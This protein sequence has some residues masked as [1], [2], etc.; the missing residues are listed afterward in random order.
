MLPLGSAFGSS[1]PSSAAVVSVLAGSSA[2]VVS[3]LAGSSALVSVVSS[4]ALVS[5]VSSGAS[6]APAAAPAPARAAAISTANTPATHGARKPERRGGRNEDTMAPSLSGVVE[7]R[8]CRG[9][10]RRRLGDRQPAL[11]LL[12]VVFAVEPVATR[13]GCREAD[14]GARVGGQVLGD[15]EVAEGEVVLGRVG[16][17]HVQHDLGPGRGL[18]GGRGP[19]GVDALQLLLGAAVQFDR[20][21][22][23]GL[24]GALV[25]G[26]VSSAVLC[27]RDGAAGGGQG[28]R[29]QGRNGQEQTASRHRGPS[30][31]REF[32]L[33]SGNSWLCH[34]IPNISQE[35]CTETGTRVRARPNSDSSS[36]RSRSRARNSRESTVPFGVPITSAASS[37]ERPWSST[38]V[39]ATR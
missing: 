30:L 33:P 13:F 32:P 8:G 25:G 21:R 11:H 27:G 26:T 9:G 37:Q 29:D 6:W 31:V 39:T 38:N 20:R 35:F 1:A 4:T 22:L 10:C 17:G 7:M 18:V 28:H 36:R 24:A 3:V 14:Q 12:L 15:L 16:V 23:G 5:V 34:R 2:S 19:G